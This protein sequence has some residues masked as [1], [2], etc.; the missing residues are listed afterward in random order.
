MSHEVETMA[1]AGEVPWH[2]LGTKV[3]EGIDA[4]E[5]LVAAG[6]DWTVDQYPVHTR[7]GEEEI[8]VPNRFALVR[9]SDNKVMTVTSKNW[10]PVQNSDVI[11]FMQDYVSAGGATLET[12]GSLHGGKVIWGL[13]RINHGFE[14]TPGDKVNGYLLIKSFHELGRATSVDTTTVRVVCQNTMTL[15]EAHSELRYKQNHMSE[16]DFSAAKERVGEA[17]ESLRLAEASAKTL[18]ALKLSAEDA[19]AKVFAPVF[20]PKAFDD[21]KLIKPEL[22]EKSRIIPK[23]LKS[24]SEAPGADPGTGWGALNAVTYYTDHVAGTDPDKR[25]TSAWAGWH[26]RAKQEVESRLLELAY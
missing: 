20:V 12:A 4:D 24:L 15:A 25:L 19:V 18:A 5:F 16:F 9:S 21:G 2:G 3:D 22:I 23:L 13:A 7:V 11:G 26:A 17:H 6:L 10:H 8:E 14:V 1:Y